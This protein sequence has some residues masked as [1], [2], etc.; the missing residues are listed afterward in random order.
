LVIADIPK[1]ESQLQHG[2]VAIS[3]A[4]RTT[5][6]FLPRFA[7]FGIADSVI[8]KFSFFIILIP[9]FSFFISLTEVKATLSITHLV[10]SQP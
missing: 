10:V 8:L 7:D 9:H 4:W 2:S 6:R 1:V 5:L 3:H